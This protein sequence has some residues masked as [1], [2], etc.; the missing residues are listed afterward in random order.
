MNTELRY[1][2]AGRI[3]QCLRGDRCSYIGKVIIGKIISSNGVVG[4][5]ANGHVSP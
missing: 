2:E 5:R 1:N 3:G 4:L